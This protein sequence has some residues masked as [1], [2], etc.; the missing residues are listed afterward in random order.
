MSWPPPDVYQL[1]M[2]YRKLLSCSCF[3]LLLRFI[4]IG[5]PEAGHGIDFCLILTLNCL[6]FII[7]FSFSL[8]SFLLRKGQISHKTKHDPWSWTFKFSVFAIV[9]FLIYFKWSYINVCRCLGL[10]GRLPA[11]P[12]PP[13]WCHLWDLFFRDRFFDYPLLPFLHP[14]SRSGLCSRYFFRFPTVLDL[15]NYCRWWTLRSGSTP[16]SPLVALLLFWVWKFPWCTLASGFGS[17]L[18]DWLNIGNFT[19]NTRLWSSTPFRFPFK[20]RVHSNWLHDGTCAP[21]L[22]MSLSII[23]T[24]P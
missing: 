21:R 24:Q 7:A 4:V 23:S 10:S 15:L 2:C 1:S 17:S 13:A 19:R 8:F 9:P 3:G 6:L 12:H 5:Q 22:L 11:E 20:N 18:L 16:V 14:L